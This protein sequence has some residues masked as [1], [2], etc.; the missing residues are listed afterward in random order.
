MCRYLAWRKKEEKLIA[1][2]INNPDQLCLIRID[3][4]TSVSLPH[5][6]NRIPKSL[7]GKDGPEVG[8]KNT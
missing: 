4:T 1:E 2:A 3:D 8:D 6:G 5:P 7:G